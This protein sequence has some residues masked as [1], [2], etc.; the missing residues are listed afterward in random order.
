MENAWRKR[1]ESAVKASGKSPRSI[2]LAAGRAHGYVHS[3]LNEGKDPTVSNLAAVCD[4]LGVD[5]AYIL[6]GVELSREH[7]ELL[8]LVQNAPPEVAEGVRQILRMHKPTE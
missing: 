1:L 4:V 8:S 2:S 3:L 6:H 7:L 5:V